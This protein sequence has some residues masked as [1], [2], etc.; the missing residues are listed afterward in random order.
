M[1]LMK[2]ITTNFKKL[3]NFTADFTEGLNVISGDNFRGKS[4]LLQAIEAALFGVTVIPGKK[5][6]IP[7]W[8]QDNFKL[9]LWFRLEPGSYYVLTRNKTTAKLTLCT[10]GGS[11][12]LVANGNTAVTAKVE[13]LLGL[14]AKDY[15]LFIQSRQHEA[16]GILTFGATALNKKVEEFA[17]VDLIDKVQGE[18]QRR[19]TLYAGYAEAKSV[20]EEEVQAA[21][22]RV[23]SAKGM[24]V[25]AEAALESA[26]LAVDTQLEVS[27]VP[28]SPTSKA[29]RQ[30]SELAAALWSE[31][32]MVEQAQAA[33]KARHADCVTRCEGLEPQ[34]S[35]ELAQKLADLKES[36]VVAAAK[37]SALESQAAAYKAAALETQRAGEASN[38]ACIAASEYA[39]GFDPEEV[40]KCS[41]ALTSATEDYDAKDSAAKTAGVKVVGLRE[42]SEGAECPT[43]GH[44]KEDHDYEKLAAELAEA[45]AAYRGLVEA[46]A[47]A[48][49]TVTEARNALTA[50]E[51]TAER[52]KSLGQAASKATEAHKVALAAL[53][54]LQNPDPSEIEDQ[55][56]IVEATRN[57]YAGLNA[58]LSGVKEH[59]ARVTNERAALQ[60]AERALSGADE[61]LAKLNTQWDELP[62]P[63]TAEQIAEVEA[64][65]ASYTEARNKWELEKATLKAAV[66]GAET[67][68]KHYE[69]HLVTATKQLEELERKNAEALEDSA[70]ARRYSRLVQFLRERRQQYL[71]DVWETIM[72]VSS[73]LVR[74]TSKDT[75]T[76][77]TNEDGEFHFVEEG[78]SAPTTSA[79]GAQ[80]SFIGTTLK[81]GLAR[82][83]Y[84]S[85]SLLIFDEPTESCSEQYASSMAAMIASSARQVLL[86]THREHDQ[87]L[88]DNIINVG[89]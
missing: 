63:P 21:R 70:K 40:A 36:G 32:Q 11:D 79:S 6:H 86:I 76:K 1:Q 9:E 41:A 23:H 12:Q 47:A 42:L 3:G 45:E 64:L 33:A 8:G 65:E 66:T 61:A 74:Q 4:T 10:V 51:K 38:Q 18:A 2:L 88:A 29:L 72:A 35:A 17:G 53:E 60:A 24:Q 16:A 43:C 82:A 46:A 58:K 69:A 44:L 57:E 62:E 50:A 7:T 75:I 68:L 73:K 54:A 48:K 27:F 15:N 5:E 26:R 59:N 52:V 83:L 67:D 25:T 28:P 77:L 31:L 85:D 14:A 20:P 55:R 22:D 81:V 71:K 78:I 37:L 19:S 39:E 89:E 84:G 80:K 30:E 87:A 49:T 13:E 34:D 56:G